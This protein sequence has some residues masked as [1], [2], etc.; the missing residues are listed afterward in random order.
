MATVLNLLLSRI[1][2]LM[3]GVR[4]VS[5][6]IA[7]DLRTPLTRL[8]YKIE[9]SKGAERDDLLKEADHLLLIFNALLWITRIETEKQRSRFQTIDL[10]SVVEDVIEFYEPLAEEK[11]ISLETSLQNIEMEGD[12]DL[13]F[14]AFANILDNALKYTPA[15]GFV[16]VDLTHTG[17]GR[18]LT[19]TDSGP[20]VNDKDLNKI[21]D[22]F[23]RTE[24]SRST[25]GTGLGLSLVAAAVE[26]HNGRVLAEN[27]NDGFRI[28]TIL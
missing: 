3:N 18:V 2:Q 20:G 25:A 1:E 8:R 12:R 10:R 26:L 5:D 14:Q 13:L 4:Q 7:H 11:N 15:G 24:E 28:I 19:V 22:R 9:Q 16:R 23:Y 6:N 17:A 27:S 21:F